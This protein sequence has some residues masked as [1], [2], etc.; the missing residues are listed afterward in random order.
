M[1]AATATADRW[2]TLVFL[3][4]GEL[5][6]WAGVPAI[7]AAAIGAAGALA[8][9]GVLHLWSVVIIGTLGSWIGGLIGGR[10]GHHV[11]RMGLDQDPPG[12]VAEG[13]AQALTSG[14]RV[15]ERWG[16]YMVFFVPSW[17]SGAMAMPFREF[18]VW[19]AAAAFLWVLAAGLGAYGIGSAASG[20]SL[21][22]T[23]LPLLAA[24]AA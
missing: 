5:L 19:N 23:L 7:G 13:R 2:S 1:L 17:V 24:A 21:A 4:F 3:F 18:A 22:E 6:A 16:R 9:Q 15:A 10:L 8:S 11:A 14:E 20:G 12:R